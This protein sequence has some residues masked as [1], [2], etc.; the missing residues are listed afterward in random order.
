VENYFTEATDST[1]MVNLNAAEGL[2][3]L[4][5]RSIPEDAAAFYFPILDWL[6]TYNENPGPSTKF[7][8]YLDYINSI[9]QKMLADV[10][11]KALQLKNSNKQ[12]K[13][14]WQYDVDDEEML[15]EGQIFAQKFN[16]DVEFEAVS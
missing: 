2:I 9:S 5:G 16:L 13:I 11:I 3:E 7:V 15:E 10:F 6:T 1:P 4:K 12:I 8:F 14:V